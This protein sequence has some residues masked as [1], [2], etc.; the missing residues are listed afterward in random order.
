MLVGCQEPFDISTTQFHPLE[1]IDPLLDGRSNGSTL[2]QF[3]LALLINLW[4]RPPRLALCSP[5]DFPG[6][7]VALGR[8]WWQ[9]NW[10]TLFLTHGGTFSS[11]DPFA[12]RSIPVCEQQELEPGPLCPT[13][14]PRVHTWAEDEGV[15]C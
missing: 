11:Q 3:C 13:A 5:I 2:C 9:K 7:R 15:L 4:F 6:V 10:C 14:R 12:L 1:R 8:T